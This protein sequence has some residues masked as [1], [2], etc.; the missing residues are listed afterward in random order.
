MAL[1]LRT[2]KLSA[3]SFYSSNRIWKVSN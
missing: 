2:C 1:I 3:Q